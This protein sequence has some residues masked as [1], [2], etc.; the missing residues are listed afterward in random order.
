MSYKKFL[1]PQIPRKARNEK[2]DEHEYSWSLL[3]CYSTLSLITSCLLSKT[4]SMYSK[5][6]MLQIKFHSLMIQESKKMI[7]VYNMRCV[8]LSYSLFQYMKRKMWKNMP[9]RFSSMK[10][11]ES[12]KYL[13]E[14]CACFSPP[15]CSSFS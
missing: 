8:L 3:S 10:T 5:I 4:G 13:I 12:N 15:S 9:R 6:K 14:L 11:F 1:L 7:C 2:A